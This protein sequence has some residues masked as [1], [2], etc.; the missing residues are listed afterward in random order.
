MIL[1][2][3]LKPPYESRSLNIIECANEFA[4]LA[5]QYVMLAFMC[6]LGEGEDLRNKLGLGF[7]ILV[8]VQLVASFTALVMMK[9]IKACPSI[10]QTYFKVKELYIKKCRAKKAYTEDLQLKNE[11][12][13][14]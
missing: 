11:I 13:Q 5:C 1:Y 2:L 4:V 10:K 7:S 12:E 14:D 9:I 6:D 8:I 3:T